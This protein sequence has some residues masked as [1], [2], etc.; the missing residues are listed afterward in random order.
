MRAHVAVVVVVRDIF[1]RM[2]VYVPLIVGRAR[3]TIDLNLSLE[4]TVGCIGF[5]SIDR[6]LFSRFFDDDIHVGWEK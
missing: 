4:L 3:E 2:C 1:L 6:I 5:G